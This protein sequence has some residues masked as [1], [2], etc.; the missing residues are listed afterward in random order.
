M[1]T[2]RFLY[3]FKRYQQEILEAKNSTED[4]A[5]RAEK[6]KEEKK[7]YATMMDELQTELDSIEKKM[8][9]PIILALASRNDGR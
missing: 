2:M 5:K 3:K 1:K 4:V 7:I 6:F 9:R 8:G